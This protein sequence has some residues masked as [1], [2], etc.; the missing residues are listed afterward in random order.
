MSK[1][2][3]G[4]GSAANDGT[5]DPLRT[6]FDK[7]NQNFTELYSGVPLN[8]VTKDANYTTVLAD[9]CTGFL[10]TSASTH[11]W[12][13]DG[14][15]AYPVGTYFTFTNENGGGNVSIAIT[16]D[17]MYLAGAGTTG[18]RTLSANGYAIAQKT[19]SGKWLISGTGLT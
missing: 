10:H 15:L 6:A 7:T 1:Q 3:I 2:S 14:S 17:S 12:T 18:T 16:T 8:F 13:I 19:S 4:I 9:G 11:T 5:G